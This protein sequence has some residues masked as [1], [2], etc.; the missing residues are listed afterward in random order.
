M[1]ATWHWVCC[2]CWMCEVVADDI[3]PEP[4]GYGWDPEPQEGNP[5]HGTVVLTGTFN[6]VDGE[7]CEG[8]AN[9][10]QGGHAY[11]RII[12]ST[13]KDITYSISGHHHSFQIETSVIQRWKLVDAEWVFQKELSVQT[14]GDYETLCGLEEIGADDCETNVAGGT[15]QFRMTANQQSPV[16]EGWE[17]IAEHEVIFTI[18][19]GESDLDGFGLEAYGELAYGTPWP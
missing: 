1:G 16:S 5:E 8:T 3:D 4:V 11:C 13:P 12:W 14:L 10:P 9:D 15:Y 2:E 18:T 6:Y 19:I 17:G 7:Y